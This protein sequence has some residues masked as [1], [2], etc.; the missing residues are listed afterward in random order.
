[1]MSDRRQHADLTRRELLKDTLTISAGAA[2]AAI[3]VRPAYAANSRTVVATTRSGKIRGRIEQGVNVFKGIPYG[4]DTSTRR[5]LPPLPAAAW[6]DT[7]DCF[8]YGPACPQPGINEAISEDCLVLNVWTPA[9]RDQS[10][11][12]IMVYFHGGEFSS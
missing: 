12:P 8:E 5:F 2:F 6:K 7:R 9:L 1:M 10:K 11:R 4:A 3:G